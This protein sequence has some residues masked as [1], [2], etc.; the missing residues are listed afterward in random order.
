MPSN[1]AFVRQ[2]GAESG[3]Q[4][5][6]LRDGSNIPATG[7][8][9]QAM[10]VIMRATRGRID[11]PFLVDRGNAV[12][13]LG[14][15]EPVRVNALNEAYVQ[16]VEGLNNGVYQAVVQ[17]LVTDSAV[18]SWL[19]V[20]PAANAFAFAVSDTEPTDTFLFA[21]KHLECFNDGIAVEF[22]AEEKKT[23]GVAVAN[24]VITVRVRD[25]DGVLIHEFTGSLNPDAKDDFGGSFY[26]P[27]VVANATDA[28]EL[29]IG[30]TGAQANVATTSSAYG[31]DA[32]G[33][34]KWATSGVQQCF[35]EGTL[36]FDTTH[37]A[38]ARR[39]L[40]NTQY[41]YAYLGSAGS[42]APGLLS[43]LAQLAFDTNRQLRF[44]VPGSLSASAAITFV[45]QLNLQ[46]GLA[47]HLLHAYWAPVK[48]NDPTGINPKGFFGTSTLNIAYACARNA[49]RNAKGF[50]PKNYPIAGR[51]FPINRSGVSQAYTPSDQE[52]NALAR[53]KV[54]PVVYETYTGGGRYVF[55]DSLTLAP[56]ENS[57]KKLISVVEMSTSID[58]AVT[59]A[60]KD[61]LQLPMAVSTKRMSDQ[62]TS[63]FEAAE[64]SGW[65]VP[66]NAPEMGGRAWAF[67]VV[68]NATRPY[69]ALDV[70]YWV[71]YDGTNRQ[72]F[73]TQTIT[74]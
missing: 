1:A 7:N 54:N 51:E 2:L 71:R 62:L 50:A 70:S 44:D 12:R 11:K 53:A 45:E 73:V 67:E 29:V 56:V 16:V 33:K 64:A 35:D 18:I 5:N 14:K 17:R 6:P 68:P 40:Q 49:Q 21:L 19:T 20:T 15:G 42:Q 46:S 34:Q 55:R 22:R 39:K 66:S 28:V 27:D 58:D 30:V 72:T 26:L 74:R 13:M 43:E 65:L 60:A 31:Y 24:D 38:A 52:L 41:D 10:G 63:M 48:T 69:D 25:A 4:L 3:V 36:V 61:A 59:R 47:P 57:L 9:D 23:G 37:Y 8:A 32:N